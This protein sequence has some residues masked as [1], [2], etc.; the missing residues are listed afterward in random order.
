MTTTDAATRGQAIRA[1]RRLTRDTVIYGLGGSGTQLVYVLFLPIFTRIFRPADFGVLDFLV[2]VNGLLGVAALIGLNSALF[3]FV[4]QTDQPERR[5]ALAGTALALSTFA[6]FAIAI[7]GVAGSGAL[8]QVLLTRPDEGAAVAMACLWVPANVAATFG[9]DLLRLEL[10]PVAYSVLAIGRSAIASG[11]GLVAAGPLGLGVAGLLGAHAVTTA[12]FAAISLWAARRS[13]RATI[14]RSSMRLMVPF[15]LPLVTFGIALWVIAYGDRFFVIQLLGTAAA[16]IYSLASRG[17]GI[18]TLVVASFEAAW[19]P[20]AMAHA[21]EPGHRD[22]YARVFATVGVGLIG[23]ATF[24]SLFAREALIVATTPDYVPA[25]AYVGLLG[26]GAAAYGIGQV[27]AVGIQLGRQ[28]AHLLRISAIAAVANVVLTVLLIPRIGI[29]GAALATAVAYV[30]STTFIYLAAQRAYP[31]PY[32]VRTVVAGAGGAL[33]AM[34]AGLFLDAMV[35]GSS[36]APMTTAAKVA[37]FVVATAWLWL[38]HRRGT[39]VHAVGPIGAAGP[40]PG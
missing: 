39:T 33:L 31:V 30:V 40:A 11:L 8:S 12:I 4:N 23:L 17:A 6:G 2:A 36:L 26:L 28:T 9:L 13:W 19:L 38:L 24:L 15:G 16:G 22:S 14:D 10:R 1:E 20:F 5:R 3:Y 27:A 37:I 29:G 7:V 32:P 35:P 25:Y 34:A 21:R 18:V